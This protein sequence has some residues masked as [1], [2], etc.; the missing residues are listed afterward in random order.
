MVTLAAR[1]LNTACSKVPKVTI[2]PRKAVGLAYLAMG[3]PR[4]G[5]DIR[6]ADR[7]FRRIGTAAGVNW[8]I[9]RNQ[10]AA[11]PGTGARN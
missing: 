1:W 11:D 7:P 2:V 10:K 3:G 4:N 9:T 5:C 8:P 6:L